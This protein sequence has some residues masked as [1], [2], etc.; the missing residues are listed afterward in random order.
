[1]L[2]DTHSDLPEHLRSWLFYQ[3][4][5]REKY[6]RMLSLDLVIFDGTHDFVYT[7]C[8]ATL[9]QG[10]DQILSVLKREDR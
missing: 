5:P 6:M 8:C 2:F 1:M 9:R 3:V 7:G 4:Q 10:I